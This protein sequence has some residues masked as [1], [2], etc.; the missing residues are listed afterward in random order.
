[1]VAVEWQR[2]E[3]H[4]N[5]QCGDGE[6]KR[7]D[8]EKET[9]VRIQSECRWRIY[10]SPIFGTTLA[11]KPL[12]ID[13]VILKE[14]YRLNSNTSKVST[15]KKLVLAGNATRSSQGIRVNCI[16]NCSLVTEEPNPMLWLLYL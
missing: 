10:S 6:K 8:S 4:D 13:L 2:Q 1:V 11:L 12:A 7:G 5:R 16:R 3:C 15:K 9:A 14:I